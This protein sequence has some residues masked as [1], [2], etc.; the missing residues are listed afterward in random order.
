MTGEL[1]VVG[2]IKPPARTYA[3]ALQNG[4]EAIFPQRAQIFAETPAN[5][6][7]DLRILRETLG[8][9]RKSCGSKLRR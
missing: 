3:G 8:S 4:L 7:E 9:L 5:L 6:C 1:R 2:K